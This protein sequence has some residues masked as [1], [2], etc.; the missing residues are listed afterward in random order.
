MKLI[1]NWEALKTSLNQFCDTEVSGVSGLQNGV[2]TVF[3]EV[4]NNP[5]QLP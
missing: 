2:K 1:F 5:L 3:L 4:A